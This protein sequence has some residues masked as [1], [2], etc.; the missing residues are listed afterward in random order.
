M[1]PLTRGWGTTSRRFRPR[2]VYVAAE[3]RPAAGPAEAV[4]PV[5]LAENHVGANVVDQPWAAEML[6]GAAYLISMSSGEVAADRSG[7]LV[8][9]NGPPSQND[10]V[11]VSEPESNPTVSVR[12]VVVGM[13]EKTISETIVILDDTDDDDTTMDT[14]YGDEDDA[15]ADI[16][17]SAVVSSDAGAAAALPPVAPSPAV[18]VESLV[19][20]TA[21]PALSAASAMATAATPG[22]TLSIPKP[23][24]AMDFPRSSGRSSRGRKGYDRTIVIGG[25]PRIVRN[26]GY[27]CKECDMTFSSPQG[28]GGHVAGHRN[29]EKRSKQNLDAVAMV[30]EIEGPTAVPGSDAVNRERVYACKR[31]SM[32]FESG[33][34]LGGHMRTHYSPEVDVDEPDNSSSIACIAAPTAAAGNSSSPSLCTVQ[35]NQEDE[36]PVVETEMDTNASAVHAPADVTISPPLAILALP[37]LNQVAELPEEMVMDGHGGTD[38]QVQ[39]TMEVCS[40]LTTT[41]SISFVS[42]PVQNQQEENPAEEMVATSRNTKR[43]IRLFGINIAEG[44]KK[45][46]S[47]SRGRRTWLF[48]L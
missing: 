16:I 24:E 7:D 38:G 14:I 13:N 21:A 26:A 39:G 17:E 37:A 41:R 34:A 33:S 4:V 12:N 31:C 8:N 45:I 35:L 42:T 48:C 3:E 47:R 43:T 44:P 19:T 32:V 1:S 2:S 30:A 28:L 40:S 27:S 18:A 15:E 5:G 22:A 9:G 29:S 25:K 36:P 23:E 10:E 11:N 20:M 6:Q 46:P